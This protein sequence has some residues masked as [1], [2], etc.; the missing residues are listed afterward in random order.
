MKN[1]LI[2]GRRWAYQAISPSTNAFDHSIAG[3]GAPD[4][5]G[6]HSITYGNRCPLT[7]TEELFSRFLV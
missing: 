6:F 7:H 3:K 1:S 4:Q 5:L 2:A